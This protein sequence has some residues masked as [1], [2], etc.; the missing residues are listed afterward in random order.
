MLLSVALT[1]L[2]QCCPVHSSCC[3]L[4]L[5]SEC[6]N[7]TLSRFYGMDGVY[8]FKAQIYRRF[9]GLT[10]FDR[11]DWV[12]NRCGKEVKYII[13]YYSIETPIPDQP[14]ETH[15]DYFIDAR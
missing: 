3:S 13:D 9:F 11:H 4:P 2:L 15:I 12:V 10:P 14:G 1:S 7:P 5:C 6:P 8:S